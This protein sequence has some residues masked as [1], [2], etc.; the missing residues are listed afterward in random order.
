MSLYAYRHVFSNERTCFWL[1]HRLRWS[2]GPLC[3]RCG[4]QSY[5]R[6]ME[7]GRP[8]YRCRVCRYHYSLLTGTELEGTRLPLTKWVLAAG[9]FAIGISSHGLARE[10]QVSQRIAWKMLTKFRQA[11]QANQIL[12]K[13]AGSVEVDETYIGGRAKGK[14]G[15]GAAHKSIVLGMRTRKGRVR[16][17][18]LLTLRTRDMQKILQSQIVKGSRLFTD[19]YYV[20]GRVRRWGFRHRRIE[21][22]KHFVRGKTHT[23]GIEGYWGHLKPT[24]TARHRSV[25][26]KHLQ[27]YLAEADV[28]HNM[29]LDA[30]FTA[31]VMQQLLSHR[32]GLP[33]K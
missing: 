29:G 10:I 28:K 18:V 31:L 24:L 3:P 19:H 9:L 5:W 2:E 17:L 26:P 16:S 25:S 23:Q 12:R 21:H 8:E 30:D 27:G 4:S 1:L 20:Y 32:R 13:L 33:S 7:H 14:R 15:R 11:L 6:M 22:A